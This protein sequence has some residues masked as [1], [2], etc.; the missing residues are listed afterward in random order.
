MNITREQAVAISRGEL[1]V[2]GDALVRVDAARD[3]G[4]G[5]EMT[6]RYDNANRPIREFRNSGDRKAWMDAFRAPVFVQTVLSKDV[7]WNKRV[8]AERLA[9]MRITS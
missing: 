7:A 8:H 3:V 2:V 5:L 4:A 9:S 6:E 1:R